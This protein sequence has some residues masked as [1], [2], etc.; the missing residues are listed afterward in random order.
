[1]GLGL[2]TTKENID[3]EFGGTISVTSTPLI[4]TKFTITI[5]LKNDHETSDTEGGQ[6]HTQ[7]SAG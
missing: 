3:I 1:M 4:G 5:P 2:S 6:F 7:Q